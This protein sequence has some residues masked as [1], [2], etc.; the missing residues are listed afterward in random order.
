MVLLFHYFLCEEGT[1]HWYQSME[2][3]STVA[4]KKSESK[5][6]EMESQMVTFLLEL[7]QTGTQLERLNLLDVDQLNNTM[8]RL[9][10]V[11]ESLLSLVRQLEAGALKSTPLVSGPI[12]SPRDERIPKYK[13]SG[14]G[15][16]QIGVGGDDPSGLINRHDREVLR[17]Q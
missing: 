4:R 5:I 1:Y 6:E 3:R 10:K 14:S 17:Q 7:N 8:N 2:T 13:A 11:E 9:P 15:Q 16:N 12:K